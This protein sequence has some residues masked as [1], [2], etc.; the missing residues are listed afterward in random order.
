MLTDVTYLLR[1]IFVSVYIE[2]FQWKRVAT[3]CYDEGENLIKSMLM[4]FAGRVNG[5]NERIVTYRALVN[6][7]AI[8]ALSFGIA[9]TREQIPLRA[10]L[11]SPLNFLRFSHFVSSRKFISAGSLRPF[12]GSLVPMPLYTFDSISAI[13]ELLLRDEIETSIA[14]ATLLKSNDPSSRRYCSQREERSRQI[15]LH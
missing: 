12:P 5:A 11:S 7:F 13:S 3:G 10:R 8:N 14:R 6:T 1:C 4:R 9:S 2:S 15:H